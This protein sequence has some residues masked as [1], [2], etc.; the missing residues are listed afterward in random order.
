MVVVEEVKAQ[1]EEVVEVEAKEDLKELSIKVMEVVEVD[2]LY[3]VYYSGLGYFDGFALVYNFEEYFGYFSL[4]GLDS[5]SYCLQS[6]FV[7]WLPID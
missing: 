5:S 7:F 2:Q 6:D 4:M 1:Q 3:L